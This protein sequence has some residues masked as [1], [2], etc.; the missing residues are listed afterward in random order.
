LQDSIQESNGVSP[1]KAEGD[2][3]G[4]ARRPYGESAGGLFRRTFTATTSSTGSIGSAVSDLH[5]LD[6]MKRKF[7]GKG[8]IGQLDLNEL[9]TCRYDTQ[10]G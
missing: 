8:D 5:Q 7:I 1:V 10:Q 9:R 3:Q 6:V 2:V 4:R